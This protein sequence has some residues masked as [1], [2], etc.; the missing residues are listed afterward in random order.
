M[1][2]INIFNIIQ[3]IKYWYVSLRTSQSKGEWYMVLSLVYIPVYKTTL[4]LKVLI[5]GESGSI[6]YTT[7]ICFS[8]EWEINTLIVDMLS[9]WVLVND[10]IHLH[11]EILLVSP[12]SWNDNKLS[13]RMYVRTFVCHNLS[14]CSVSVCSVL[15]RVGGYGE[16]GGEVGSYLVSSMRKV[17]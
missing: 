16:W 3:Q 1:N 8:L 13:I 17:N 12:K 2:S 4:P 15:R 7:C 10:R 14:G 9:T 6:V 5:D 11:G